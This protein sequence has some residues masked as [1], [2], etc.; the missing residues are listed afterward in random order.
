[1]GRIMV[2][3]LC[4]WALASPAL[5]QN[6]RLALVIGI[7][8]Y[9]SI[10]PL[11]NPPRDARA[12]AAKL[13]GLGFQTD[14]VVDPDR[15]GLER[16]IRTFGDKARNA[17]IALLFYAGHALE[18]NGQNYLVPAT[19]DVHTV[20]D[21]PFETVSLDL[22]TAQLEGQARS[23]LIFLDACRDNP[24]ATR[25]SSGQRGIN[26]RGLAAPSAN[27]TGTLVVYA[28]APG[29][30]ADDGNGEDSPFTTALLRHIDEPGL[31]VRQM[32]SRVRR[33][34][35]NATGGAQV[36][37]E[38]SSLEGDLY[39]RPPVAGSPPAAA[40]VP[41][42]SATPAAVA[43]PP[44]AAVT[45]NQTAA[46]RLAAPPPV[47][48]AAPSMPV[49]AVTPAPTAAAH[50]PVQVAS[51]RPAM[52]PEA[53]TVRQTCSHPYFRGMETAAGA[54]AFM[55]VVNNGSPCSIRITNGGRPY[56]SLA[57]TQQARHG[58]VSIKDSSFA[59]TPAA[60]FT[61]SDTFKVESSPT[62][63][64]TGNVTVLPSDTK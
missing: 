33:D 35:R 63:L 37:W 49:V 10:S 50:M 23:L 25:I 20:R 26:A 14:L 28:T 6:S 51:A 53:D 9:K 27:A 59:Y 57:V 2:M 52:L 11:K 55:T 45:A 61:G 13:R 8:N 32:L 43:P 38:S 46:P 15:Q 41:T 19:A 29:R 54:V 48:A 36:P 17:D 56:K 60:G 42:P 24:F 44:P 40:Q 1:M 18:T 34:V 21:V 5:G 64:V 3:L 39:F 58:T 30:T 4:C 47:Q 62:G 7:G 22:V 31:E 16:A 12:M